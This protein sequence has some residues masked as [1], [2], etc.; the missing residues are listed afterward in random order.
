MAD[1]PMPTLEA[2]YS[3]REFLAD[4]IW[5]I[6]GRMSACQDRN[7]TCELDHAHIEA[8][9]RFRLSYDTMN[10]IRERAVAAEGREKLASHFASLPKAKKGT[11]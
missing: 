9:R 5:F 1:R 10:E 7:A 4:I 8:L 3:D 6:K 11:K 2:N